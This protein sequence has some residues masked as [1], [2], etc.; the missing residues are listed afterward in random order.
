MFKE[1]FKNV[2]R[3]NCFKWVLT[4]S[5]T[6]LNVLQNY[7]KCL[8]KAFRSHVVKH[9]SESKSASKHPESIPNASQNLRIPKVSQNLSENIAI[10][11]LKHSEKIRK[12]PSY[13][14]VR[15]LT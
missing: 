9:P 13:I 11:S 5:E 12:Y 1:S 6:S 7:T 4:H 8:S 10:T 15:A 2:F 14:P 3:R